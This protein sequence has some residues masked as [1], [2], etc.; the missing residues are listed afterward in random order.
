MYSILRGGGD[1][2]YGI[3]NPPSGKYNATWQEAFK[4]K[5]MRL[6]GLYSVPQSLLTD[7]LDGIHGKDR[8]KFLNQQEVTYETL[9]KGKRAIHHLVTPYES[10]YQDYLTMKNTK[11]INKKANKLKKIK[12]ELSEEEKQAHKVTYSTPQYATSSLLHP[13]HT[14]ITTN[15]PKTIKYTKKLSELI[16]SKQE[17]EDEILKTGDNYLSSLLSINNQ[18]I[19]YIESSSGKKFISIL[20]FKI[21]DKKILL[22]QYKNYVN[23]GNNM[24]VK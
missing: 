9:E 1:K 18:I 20:P 17:V 22:N 12:K 13:M 10:K 19:K 15:N 3:Y 5:Q 24:K 2:Y 4:A 21:I 6:W 7:H 16:K 11:R 14:V 23:S 8:T